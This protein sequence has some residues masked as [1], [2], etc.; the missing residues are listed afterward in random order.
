MVHGG[1]CPWLLW[2][3]RAGLQLTFLS[4]ATSHRAAGDFGIFER[5]NSIPKR[6][7]FVVELNTIPT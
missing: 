2:L 7:L 4:T 6:H 3:L 1:P 5:G